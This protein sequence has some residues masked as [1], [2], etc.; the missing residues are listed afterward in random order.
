MEDLQNFKDFLMAWL[1]SKISKCDEFLEK[2]Q[3]QLKNIKVTNFKIT[4]IF[5]G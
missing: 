4:S 2:I 1:K 5:D 3:S